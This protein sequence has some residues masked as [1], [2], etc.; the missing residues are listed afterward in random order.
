MTSAAPASRSTRKTWL[1][2]PPSRRVSDRVRPRPARPVSVAAS[3]SR[4]SRANASDV[5]M[6]KLRCDLGPRR[7]ALVLSFACGSRQLLLWIEQDAA[8]ARWKARKRKNFRE[9]VDERIAAQAGHARD[10]FFPAQFE[11][12]VVR[13][14]LAWIDLPAARAD[15]PA[16]CQKAPR[17]GVQI[18]LWSANGVSR[19]VADDEELVPSLP[20]S[21]DEIGKAAIGCRQ[22]HAGA[23][24]MALQLREILGTADP[25][26][27]ITHAV[28]VAPE[29]FGDQPA[30]QCRGVKDAIVAG[31]RVVEIDP[32]PH[33][34][35][36]SDMSISG[37]PILP[38]A[39]SCKA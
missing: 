33:G 19:L 10:F 13:I 9:I 11:E 4:S 23:I 25:V 28:L 39:R 16:R 8:H 29:M 36:R 38:E 34:Y 21:R 7:T 37:R 2:L 15:Q 3:A 27:M 6:A 20:R 14:D 17:R 26:E 32:D 30:L 31:D 12:D 35:A 24:D 22:I 5:R 1:F 18:I